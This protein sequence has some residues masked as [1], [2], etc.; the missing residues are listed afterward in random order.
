MP[1]FANA[2]HSSY[3]PFLALTQPLILLH[4]TFSLSAHITLL[5]GIHFSPFA[6]HFFSSLPFVFPTPS[7]PHSL[8]IFISHSSHLYLLYTYLIFLPHP[9]STLS[10]F[11][12]SFNFFFLSFLSYLAPFTFE[13]FL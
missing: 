4:P 8:H 3:E 10:F 1:A 11:S 12:S 5:F 2:H 6:T 7:A 9:L 13:P